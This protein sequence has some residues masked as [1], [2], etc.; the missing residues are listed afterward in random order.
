MSFGLNNLQKFDICTIYNTLLNLKQ[1]NDL[2][3]NSINVLINNIIKQ[4]PDEKDKE[5][6]NCLRVVL[7]KSVSDNKILTAIGKLLLE[8]LS[9]KLKEKCDKINKGGYIDRKLCFNFYN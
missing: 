5:Y 2:N 1:T 4:L 7:N 3:I 8:S 6:Y 9:E